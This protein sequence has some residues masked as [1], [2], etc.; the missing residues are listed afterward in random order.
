MIYSEVE[1]DQF[2]EEESDDREILDVLLF[3]L[4][5]LALLYS[6]FEELLY[7]AGLGSIQLRRTSDDFYFPIVQ[8][9]EGVIVAGVEGKV[10]KVDVL[11][12]RLIV[13]LAQQ[14]LGV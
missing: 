2:I 9:T 11:E 4:G 12:L 10:M 13:L 5:I 8:E 14:I 7:L 1:V 3:Y 6:F